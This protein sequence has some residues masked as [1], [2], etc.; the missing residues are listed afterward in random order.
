MNMRMESETRQ[1]PEILTLGDSES[2][3]AQAR[4][5]WAKFDVR[6]CNCFDET[7]KRRMMSLVEQYPGGVSCFNTYVRRLGDSLT[8]LP[9]QNQ[10]SDVSAFS[11]TEFRWKSLDVT[12][13]R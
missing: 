6:S 13:S 2:V 9:T 10:H 5:D 1:L 3:R 8:Q 12:L 4:H 7:D 11:A